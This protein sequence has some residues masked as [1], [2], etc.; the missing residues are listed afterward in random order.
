MKNEE[1]NSYFD[2]I[3][4]LLSTIPEPKLAYALQ[5]AKNINEVDKIIVGTTCVNDLEEIVENLKTKIE[6]IDYD[7]YKITDERFILPQN[8]EIA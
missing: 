4:P 6:N 7:K 1:I 5:F 3:K 8:W 2:E